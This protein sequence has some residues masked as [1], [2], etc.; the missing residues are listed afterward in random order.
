MSLF[1]E[2]QDLYDQRTFNQRILNELLSNYANKSLS[3]LTNPTAINQDL[4]PNGNKNF[5]NSSNLWTIYTNGITNSTLTSPFLFDFTRTDS[6]PFLRNRRS[7]IQRGFS[8]ATSGTGLQVFVCQDML[9]TKQPVSEYG[10][11]GIYNNLTDVNIFGFNNN[12]NFCFLQKTVFNPPTLDSFN[13]TAQV[14]F[15]TKGNNNMDSY[16]L[17]QSSSIV[18]HRGGILFSNTQSNLSGN[19]SYKISSSSGNS[20]N[21]TFRLTLVENNSPDTALNTILKIF[22][23]TGQKI[24]FGDPNNKGQLRF[25]VPDSLDLSDFGVGTITV[26]NCT[27]PPNVQG[28]DVVTEYVENNKK[29]MFLKNGFY[30][31]L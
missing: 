5:G 16:F 26:G 15:I 2:V 19:T 14:H 8:L 21:A 11:I 29:K 9:V 17:V 7:D 6:Y 10:N 30:V 25:Y 1:P 23:T 27:T 13:T 12:N 22:G 18:G 3:N 24:N 20:L 4:I 28:R 31:T